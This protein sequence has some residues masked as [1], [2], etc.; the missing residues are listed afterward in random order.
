MY[1]KIQNPISHLY[2]VLSPLHLR[3][4]LLI[5]DSSIFG[6]HPSRFVYLTLWRCIHNLVRPHFL[7]DISLSAVSQSEIREKMKNEKIAKRKSCI[8]RWSLRCVSTFQRSTGSKK[9]GLIATSL[10]TD[11]INIAWQITTNNRRLNKHF[12]S[13]AQNRPSRVFP[14]CVHR[15]CKAF[16]SILIADF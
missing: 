1:I 15:E 14:S 9:T 3:V 10:L 11:Q 13:P 8:S 12:P 16:R 2:R 5:S 7:S 4:S 6:L